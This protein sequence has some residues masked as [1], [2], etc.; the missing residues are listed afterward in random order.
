MG[1]DPACG[2]EQLLENE[3]ERR[4]D[5]LENPSDPENDRSEEAAH[6]DN[7]EC[8][9]PLEQSKEATQKKPQ[10]LKEGVEYAINP[11]ERAAG[12]ARL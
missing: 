9:H 8:N 11:E 2:L 12:P 4:K 7:D 6:Q 1:I 3:Q 5:R 10:G